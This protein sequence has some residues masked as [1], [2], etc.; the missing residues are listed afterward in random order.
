[1]ID[2]NALNV[3]ESWCFWQIHF[4]LIIVTLRLID[5][6]ECKGLVDRKSISVLQYSDFDYQILKTE[7]SDCGFFG[8]R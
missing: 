7:M 1:M 8:G 2:L 6:N 5:I 3:N 4:S